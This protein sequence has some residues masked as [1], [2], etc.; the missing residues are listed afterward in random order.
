MLAEDAI[1]AAIKD[2]KSKQDT[3]KGS[4]AAEAQ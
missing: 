2:Y 1:Q 3:A 4:D